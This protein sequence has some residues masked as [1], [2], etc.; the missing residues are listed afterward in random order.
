VSADPVL[1]A[2]LEEL[3]AYP[4]GVG[5][6]GEANGIAILLKVRQGPRLLSFLSM[7]TVF[8]TPIDITLSEL[9]I[10]AFLPADSA[11]A[12]YLRG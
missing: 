11:T 2:L 10:E 5:D 4:G 6:P 3:R 12:E 8:G 9:A 1:A 7:T